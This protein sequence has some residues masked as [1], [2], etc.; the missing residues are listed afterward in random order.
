M[1]TVG[2]DG[3]EQPIR[4]GIPTPSRSDRQGGMG[5]IAATWSEP[6]HDLASRPGLRAICVA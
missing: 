4:S 1:G 3:G 6:F 5:I 2:R